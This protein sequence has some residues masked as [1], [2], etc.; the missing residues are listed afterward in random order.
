MSSASSTATEPI[1]SARA[2]QTEVWHAIQ[3][4]TQRVSLQRALE[5]QLRRADRD[6]VTR[7]ELRA[8]EPLSV[9]LEAVRRVE[10]DD[11]VRRPLLP[12]LR[13]LPRHVR[14]G[15]LD[16]AVARASDHD[17]PLCHLVL[18]PVI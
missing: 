18:L 11:P 6:P 3:R 8:L 12:H 16:V 5:D 1:M 17:P 4:W 13:M 7:L 2:C 10:V 14:I 9:H 15:D